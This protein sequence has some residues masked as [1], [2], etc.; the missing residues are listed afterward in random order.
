[1]TLHWIWE[2]AWGTLWRAAH[3]C[4][5]RGNQVS[6]LRR[7]Q[8]VLVY[9]YGSVSEQKDSGRERQQSSWL[10]ALWLC[11]TCCNSYRNKSSTPCLYWWV[12]S[13]HWGKLLPDWIAWLFS[14]SSTC[15]NLHSSRGFPDQPRGLLAGL[16]SSSL[17]NC[18]LLNLAVGLFTL[19]EC[20]LI[21]PKHSFLMFFFPPSPVPSHSPPKKHFLWTKERR[22]GLFSTTSYVFMDFFSPQKHFRINCINFRHLSHSKKTK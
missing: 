8:Q 3:S 19:P 21:H 1:M 2:S 15:L 7:G 5:G 4:S 20:L 6:S 12:L 18:R 22:G 14:S 13:S 9:S 17:W 16:L 10:R 11:V